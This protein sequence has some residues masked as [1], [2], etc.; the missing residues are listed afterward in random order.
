MESLLSFLNLTIGKLYIPCRVPADKQLHF[1]SGV[2]LTAI[3][4]P[5]GVVYALAV[6]AGIAV[7]KEIYDYL[8]R[9]VHTP[10][11]FDALATVCG[12]AVTVLIY[13]VF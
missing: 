9:D 8:H 4:L 7:A 6:V 10:D 13:S 12:G 2:L 3:L 5:L 1:V 11:I